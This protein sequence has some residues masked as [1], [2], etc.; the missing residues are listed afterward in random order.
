MKSFTAE[1]IQ[2]LLDYHRFIPYLKQC[3]QL[4]IN[5]PERAHHDLPN[6]TLLLMPAWNEALLGIK[7]ATVHPDNAA[8]DLPSIHA[9]YLLSSATTGE[10]LAL[11]EGKSLTVKR[12]AAASALAASFLAPP[13]ATR[14]LMIGNGA[15]APELIKAYATVRPIE[16]VQIWGR[17]AA[18]VAHLIDNTDWQHL[19][20]SRADDLQEAVNQSDIIS[21]A[22]LSKTPLLRGEW[23]RPGQHLDLAGSFKPDMRE[24][25]DAVVQ[26]ALLFVDTPLALKE[27]GDLA[28]PLQKAI[29]QL[30]DIQADLQKLCRGEHPGRIDSTAIT[31]FKSV[32]FALEDLAAAAYILQT[33][34]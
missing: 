32:G 15:L 21:C 5:V 4:A 25:D 3:F 8:L 18:H 10:P 27:S 31:V 20:V 22:T 16:E 34:K 12:T 13:D 6:G 11:F 1:H 28:I 9:T 33:S 24:A 2:A 29:I 7:F 30:A 14:L 19:K 26:R 23:L 17:N